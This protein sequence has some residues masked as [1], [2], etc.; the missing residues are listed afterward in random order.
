[1][2]S[3]L[4]KGG[5]IIAILILAVFL[6]ITGK[7]HAIFITNKGET[8]TPKKAY[9][10]LDG[11]E[12]EVKIKKKK[13]KREYVKGTSHTIEVRFKDRDGNEK[14]ISRDFEAKIGEKISINVALIEDE[15]RWIT[16]EKIEKEK[17]NK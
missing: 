9:Y 8:Y 3:I 5:V 7:E 17:R 2:K 13:K 1:M 6:F 11:K 12:K 10:I 16:K 4:V 15:K 14:K